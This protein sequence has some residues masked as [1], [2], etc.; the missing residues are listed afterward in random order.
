MEETISLR[1][2]FLVLKKRLTLI[3]AMM[4]A[5]LGAAGVV[6]FFVITPQ[7][8]SR[9]QLIVTLPNNSETGTATANDVNTN[10]LM[11]NTYKEMITGDL[12]LEE[13]QSQLTSEYDYKLTIQEIKNSLSVTQN[14]NSLMFSIVATMDDATVAKNVANTTAHVFRDTAKDVLNDT[15]DKISI[16]SNAAAEMTPVSPNNKL[17]LAIGVVL[18]LMLGVGL[19]FLLELLDK[20]VKD[21]KFI[22]ETLGYTILGT[23]PRMSTDEQNA[24]ISKT[25]FTANIITPNSNQ[26]TPKGM[27]GDEQRRTRTR[28]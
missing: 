15:V 12:A 5:G 21:D 8:S 23:V 27:D 6:T 14:D 3:I 24:T 17:N 11:I 19:A 7:Y 1:E 18:G 16:I 2:I 28:V 10:L 4:F 25:H 9:A 26:K 20:T 13:V 22:T